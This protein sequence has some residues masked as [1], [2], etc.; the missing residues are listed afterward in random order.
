MQLSTVQEAASA[1]ALRRGT[2]IDVRNA[3]E[4]AAGH[5]PGAMFMPL[6]T[7]PLRLADLD[8][9]ESYFVV[10]DSGARSF[11]ACSYLAQHGYDVRNVHGGMS[12]W[13]AAGLST[14]SGTFD[15]AGSH[16]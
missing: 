8:R 1:R 11:Q 5:A 16:S 3:D 4:F 10:C 2:I 7:V 13:R 15:F 14:E 9:R 6:P 12:A